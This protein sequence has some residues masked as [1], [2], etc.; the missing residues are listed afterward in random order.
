MSD[1]SNRAKEIFLEALNHTNDVTAFIAGACGS[2]EDLRQRVEA[3]LDANNEAGDFLPASSPEVSMDADDFVE[4]TQQLDGSSRKTSN[5]IGPYKLLEE[6]GEGGMGTVWVA[7]QSKPIKR[8]VALKLIKAGMD[9]KQV[10]ARFEAERQAL[11]MMDHPNIARVVDAGMTEQ[12]RP[13]FA[14]EYVKGVPLT[15]YCDHAKLSVKERLELFMLVCSA[16]QHAHQKGI[17][18]RDLKPSNILVCLYDGKPVP[19]VIDF[20]LAKAMHQSLTEKTLHTSHGMMVGTPMYMSPEQAESNNLDVDT[21]TDVYSLGVILYELLTGTTPLEKAQFKQAAVNEIL[22]LI[23]EE[24]ALKPSSRLSG[25]ASLPNLAAQRSIDP[26]QLARQISGDLD[27]VV[28]KALEKERSRRYE[29]ANGLAADIQ[30]HLTDEPVSASPPSAKYRLQ[31]FVKRN[32]VGVI[33]ASLVGVALVLAVVGT[34]WGMWSASVAAGKEA[35]QREIAEQNEQKAQEAT[36]LAKQQ[37]SQLKQVARNFAAMMKGINPSAPL[38]K[39]QTV[40]DL[41]RI[42]AEEMAKLLAPDN[43]GDP[44]IATELKQ[45]MGEALRDLKSPEK[46]LQLL[47]QVLEFKKQELGENDPATLSAQYHV[48]SVYAEL[49]QQPKAL[50]LLELTLAQ[51]EKVLPAGHPDIVRSLKGLGMIHALMGKL[52]E[53]IKYSERAAQ[54]IEDYDLGLPQALQIRYN[55]MVAYQ[56]LAT[57]GNAKKSAAKVVEIADKLSLPPGNPFV[58]TAQFLLAFHRA[59]DGELDAGIAEM[60]RLSELAMQARGVF[61]GHGLDLLGDAYVRVGR[62][63]DAIRLLEDAIDVIETSGATSDDRLSLVRSYR[64]SLFGYRM[65]ESRAA[66]DESCRLLLTLRHQ[67]HAASEAGPESDSN[68]SVSR[69]CALQLARCYSGIGDNSKALDVLKS[70]CEEAGIDPDADI[71]HQTWIVHKLISYCYFKEGRLPESVILSRKLLKYFRTSTVPVN[72]HD[73]LAFLGLMLNKLES[74]EEAEVHLRESWNGKKQMFPGL[75]ETFETQSTLGESL[76]GQ[77]KWK[78]AEQ[79]LLE[80]FQGMKER[81]D[82]MY[83]HQKSSLEKAAKRLVRLYK[84]MDNEANAAKWQ[85]TVEELHKKYPPISPSKDN[86]DAAKKSATESSKI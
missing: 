42:R 11:A 63:G 16:V 45:A 79:M 51:R 61:S 59:Y 39:G 73:E 35:K 71:T 37:L 49:G 29:T 25:S 30:R 4:M 57:Y 47:E 58:H 9:S 15:E 60:T 69:M 52:P 67:L 27:W 81:E 1:S 38:P 23:T 86:A 72:Y 34:S 2:D 78:E 82:L 7:E 74:Y 21:R 32:R 76:L 43:V 20:G 84:A 64:V 10:L 6:I 44:F 36:E 26:G 41:L 83:W 56:N 3:L 77:E 85:K 54:L 17:I 19:K 18:H 46:A 8:K 5:Q 40:Y 75:W 33:T 50:A 13:Y 53:S 68:A 14:M 12:G 55:I 28:M 65:S 70:V 31:K 80:G 24:E 66:A 48:A 22:R 62:I